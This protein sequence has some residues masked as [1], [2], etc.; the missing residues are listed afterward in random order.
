MQLF[1]HRMN[2]TAHIS[3]QIPSISNSV[4]T[5]ST[6][7]ALYFV[8]RPASSISVVFAFS[9]FRAS[10]R[11]PVWRSVV[12]LSAAGEGVFTDRAV[13][14]QGVFSGSR[15]LFFANFVSCLLTAPYGKYF[16]AFRSW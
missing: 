6:G 10:L 9:F 4:E 8:A 16:F 12:R 11:R 7:S 15:H 14:P 3:L 5:K 2:Q 13:G 1:V